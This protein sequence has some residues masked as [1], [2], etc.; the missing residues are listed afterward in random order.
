MVHNEYLLSSFTGEG[1]LGVTQVS[2]CSSIGL[3]H[4]TNKG[5]YSYPREHG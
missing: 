2:G 5:F 3:F 1:E 4:L